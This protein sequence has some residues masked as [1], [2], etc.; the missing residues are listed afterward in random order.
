[1]QIFLETDRLHPQVKAPNTFMSPILPVPG[2]GQVRYLV[3]Q[4]TDK[5]NKGGG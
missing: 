4:L 1:M 2:G 3:V 5:D